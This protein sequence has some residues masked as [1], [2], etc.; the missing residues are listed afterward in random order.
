MVFITWTGASGAEGGMRIYQISTG[1]MVTELQTASNPGFPKYG[2]YD[3]C[4]RDGKIYGNFPYT[5]TYGQQD[6][7]GIVEINLVDYAC[8]Y[9][10]PSY[11]T[12]D[13][14]RLF[15]PRVL[16]S[17]E[18]LFE[19]WNGEGVVL[20]DPDSS[21]WTQ[22]LSSAI[23]GL[24]ADSWTGNVMYDELTGT[25]FANSNGGGVAAFSRYGFLYKSKIVEANYTTEWEFGA[26]PHPDL[27]ILR[28]DDSPRRR[29]HDACLLA[30]RNDPRFE[31]DRLGAGLRVH[32]PFRI[33]CQG[34]RHYALPVDRREAVLA[35]VYSDARAP[36][37]S[38]E[39]RIPV[40]AV[41]QEN[42]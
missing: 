42:A 2:L 24:P 37:R 8:V 33:H 31:D 17:G 5:D 11:A 21:S 20:W 29:R 18:I 7:R 15:G 36:V 10:R 28:G 23:P 38:H 19:G 22:Y 4:Y 16:A 14:Y 34:A 25:I 6:R 30:E 35:G 1:A 40:A 13:D 27:E 9:Y 41:S 26:G 39:P 32:R 12:K 3:I